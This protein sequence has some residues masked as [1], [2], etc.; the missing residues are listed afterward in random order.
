MH[1]WFRL[2]NFHFTIFFFFCYP[3]LGK[4]YFPLCLPN[5]DAF[6]K[7]NQL[8]SF[9]LENPFTQSFSHDVHS[10]KG[11]SNQP[12]TISRLFENINVNAHLLRNLHRAAIQALPNEGKIF[13]SISHLSTPRV[14]Q[15]TSNL[16][17]CTFRHTHSFVSKINLLWT[18]KIIR[19]SFKNCVMFVER[20]K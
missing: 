18:I 19:D 4:W 11:H 2:L 6:L 9:L 1:T 10:N 7:F 5:H 14:F 12:Y 3:P 17:Q 16:C 20:Q 15:H 13:P 8:E